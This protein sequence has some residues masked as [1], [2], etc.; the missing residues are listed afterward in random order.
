MPAKI[1]EIKESDPKKFFLSRIAYERY[2]HAIRASYHS[3]ALSRSISNA[4]LH[5]PEYESLNCGSML[6]AMNIAIDGMRRR[7]ANIDI[8]LAEQIFDA[9]WLRSLTFN[10]RRV[11]IPIVNEEGRSWYDESP[12]MNFDFLVESF[13]GMHYDSKIIYD[14]GGHQGVWALY[15]STVI[16]ASG[17]V[18]TFEPS[19]VNVEC[20]ALSFLLN[21]IE[22]GIIIPFGIG[23]E[24]SR[25]RPDQNG[26]LIAGVSHNINLIK[27]DWALWEKPDFIKIDIEGYEHELLQSFPDLFDYCSNMHLEI[28]VPHLNARG[29]DYRDIFELIPFDRVRVRRAV[30]GALQEVSLSDE[31]DGFCT[32]LITER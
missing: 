18:Y 6:D 4:A 22:N 3:L 26:L 23:P 28:H 11:H 5:L 19:I 27:L 13:C 32:L 29:I 15:Y 25:I 20:A 14:I 9:P 30:W 17:R 12:M 7:L 31:L 2:M 1:A 16:H 21:G 10:N 8:S 24:N